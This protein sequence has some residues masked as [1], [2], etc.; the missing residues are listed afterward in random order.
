MWRTG[1]EA[2]L[3]L[4]TPT[5]SFGP[6]QHLYERPGIHH[7]KFHSPEKIKG[8]LEK[9]TNDR[10][11][12][13][14]IYLSFQVL[15][16]LQSSQRRIQ[17]WNHFHAVRNVGYPS[18]HHIPPH[19]ELSEA[20]FKTPLKYNGLR[21]RANWRVVWEKRDLKPCKYLSEHSISLV[22]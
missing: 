17:D 5:W 1:S 14:A 9:I 20:C 21:S 10:E 12:S 2:C 19:W 7:G 8:K 6:I 22:W 13:K 3:P 11:S 15:I 16:L 18:H 4:R